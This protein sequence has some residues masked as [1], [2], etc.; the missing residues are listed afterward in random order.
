MFAGLLDDSTTDYLSSKLEKFIAIAPIVFL[1][2]SPAPLFH[3]FGRLIRKGITNTHTSW[4]GWLE[5]MSPACAGAPLYKK[6]FAAWF[7]HAN[8][9]TNKL[10]NNLV[11]G[12]QFQPEFDS[13]LDNMGRL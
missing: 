7:C 3:V 8:Y 1:N 6:K 4:L 13:I 10:C 9:Y 2:H 12:V 11:P 5:F